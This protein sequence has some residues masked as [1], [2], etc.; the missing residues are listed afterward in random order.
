MAKILQ[1]A[2]NRRRKFLIAY[3]TKADETKYPIAVL[4]NLTLSELEEEYRDIK[5][6]TLRK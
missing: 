2:I 6:N 3:L 4:T 5:E 1:N